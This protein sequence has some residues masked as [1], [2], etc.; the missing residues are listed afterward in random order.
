MTTLVGVLKR[1]VLVGLGFFL[2]HSV[3]VPTNN[4]EILLLCPLQRLDDHCGGRAEERRGSGPGV[5]PP[6]R[7]AGMIQP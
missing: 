6:G 2:L 4:Y 5:L 7:C 1:E 3:L